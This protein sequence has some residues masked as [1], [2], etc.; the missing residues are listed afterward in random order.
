M[1][2]PGVESGEGAGLRVRHALLFLVTAFLPPL[3][4]EGL[5]IV[6]NGTVAPWLFFNV[7]VLFSA[8]IGGLKSGLTTTLASVA[9]AWWFFNPPQRSIAAYDRRHLASAV[10]FVIIGVATSLFLERLRSART[11]TVAATHELRE[12]QRVVQSVIDHAPGIVV[13]KDLEGKILLF[14]RRF[15]QAVGASGSRLRGRTVYDL[16]SPG[17]ARRRRDTDR[18]VI[19]SRRPVTLEETIS[20]ND[21]HHVFLAVAFPLLDDQ[22]APF[23]VCWM[24]T[25]ITAMKQA[26]E[27]LGRT[28][29]DL[30][31]AQR[32]GHIGSWT[33]D[34]ESDSI[35]WSE[36]LYRIHRRDPG[37]PPPRY[38]ELGTVFTPESAQAFRDALEKLKTDGK[39]FELEAE[40]RSPDSPRRWIAIRGE[41]MRGESG[42]VI[43]VRGTSQDIT[44][45]K[46]LERMKEEW[47]SVIAHDLRQPIGA[48]KMA[49]D[50]LPDLHAAQKGDEER[51]ITARIGKAAGTLARMVDDLLDV[52]RLE[53]HRLSLDRS[54]VDLRAMVQDAIDRLAH[55]TAG[56]AVT[57]AVYG[58]PKKVFADAGR[59]EQVLGNLLSNAVKYGEKD[60]E[61]RVELATRPDEVEVSVTNRGRGIL[62]EEMDQLFTRFG[63]SKA[64]RESGVPGLGL[65]L[66]IAKGL[67]EAHGGHM[68][69]DSVPNEATTFRFTVPTTIP[70]RAAA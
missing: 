30:K 8:W 47:T 41:A 35:S 21:G 16:F 57:M 61:V 59:L 6:F 43:G 1:G 11:A 42:R 40:A 56:R 69:V 12:S 46:E 64:T 24:E 23:G 28:A 26:E 3:V 36:E 37:V 60:A 19:D 17:D 50:L 62:P 32:V 15:A 33:W 55:L 49:A 5:E 44:H 53:A 68:W 54:W 48:I 10:V 14:N 38:A 51:A 52:S 9:I 31:Q 58:P 18:A 27:D 67:V 66:Y 45:L 65:G 22:G 20:L 63:R 39:A 25:D 70:A 29:A 7:A 13:A 34:I 4:A 2:G